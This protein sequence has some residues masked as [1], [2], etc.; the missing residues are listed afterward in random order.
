MNEADRRIKVKA[1]MEVSSTPLTAVTG[2]PCGGVQ[3]VD[4]PI[5]C[6]MSLGGLPWLASRAQGSLALARKGE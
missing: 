6:L 5:L 2:S 3:F 4:S 1:T